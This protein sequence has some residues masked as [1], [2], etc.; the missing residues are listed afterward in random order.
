MAVSSACF[1]VP[2]LLQIPCSRKQLLQTHRYN[3]SSRPERH[4]RATL[5]HKC[6]SQ[7]QSQ[8]NSTQKEKE[9]F[10]F[11]RLFSNLNQATLKREP[12]FPIAIIFFFL[13]EDP[14]TMLIFLCSCYAFQFSFFFPFFFFFFFF[15]GSLS[16]AIF[17]V[18]GTTVCVFLVRY[19]HFV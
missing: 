4:D 15:S 3:R 6:F 19:L 10:E 12:G 13:D 18:A 8:S 2:T 11:E 17:L 14:L 16:S 1:Q 7:R 5:L 9:E